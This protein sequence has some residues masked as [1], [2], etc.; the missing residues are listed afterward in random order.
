M[1]NELQD[2]VSGLQEAWARLIASVDLE[3]TW[4]RLNAALSEG[5]VREGLAVGVATFIAIM[6][7]GKLFAR[8]S[9][10]ETD[11]L[12]ERLRDVE[13]QLEA[14]R[15]EAAA[16]KRA[17]AEFRKGDPQVFA[18]ALASAVTEGGATGRRHAPDSW[19]DPLRTVLADAYLGS[20]RAILG[21][22][23]GEEDLARARVMAWGAMA[24]EPKR[25][26]CADLLTRIDEAERLGLFSE[27]SEADAL[28]W[29]IARHDPGAD[30]EGH[31][32]GLISRSRGP[33][34]YSLFLSGW[35]ADELHAAAIAELASHGVNTGEAA[36]AEQKDD[37][38]RA[39]G[40]QRNGKK[41]GGEL[42]A[43]GRRVVALSNDATAGEEDDAEATEE[44][45]VMGAGNGGNGR[46]RTVVVMPRGRGGKGRGRG[47]TG[48]GG[49]DVPAAGSSDR[50]AGLRRLW[51]R[52]RRPDMLGETH[53]RTL[54]ARANLGHEAGR[55]G[56]H[57]EAEEIFREVLEA[58]VGS[59]DSGDNE[60]DVMTVRHNLGVELLRQDKLDEAENEF[61]AVLGELGSPAGRGRSIPLALAAAHGLAEVWSARGEHAE[62]KAAFGAVW[63]ARSND[64][65]FGPDHPHT[66][67][68]RVRMLRAAEADAAAG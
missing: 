1:G 40:G 36:G 47:V 55:L 62:A 15:G 65:A 31:A 51:E 3:T 4:L 63:R 60:L 32:R 53:P 7:I 27:L 11:V 39:A 50:E 22:V 34:G 13:L 9:F 66:L 26:E 37:E 30:P 23:R 2:L 64:D 21:K 8:R 16:A 42:A 10:D 41:K 33:I 49:G 48:D 24:A 52:R 38:D 43:E 45:R 28:A 5:P 56:R 19:L 12:R 14:A 68:S 58:M 29:R 18:R 57:A 44:A 20:A 35:E 17:H 67:W 46:G 61:K 25:K 6:L 59:D 54:A